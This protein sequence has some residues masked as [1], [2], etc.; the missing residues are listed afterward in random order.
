MGWYLSTNPSRDGSAGNR[1][2]VQQWMATE[3]ESDYSLSFTE[4]SHS[5]LYVL[6]QYSHKVANKVQPRAQEDVEIVYVLC[7]QVY[8]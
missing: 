1:H 6:Y 2:Y 8:P 7:D 4:R 5:L 3:V